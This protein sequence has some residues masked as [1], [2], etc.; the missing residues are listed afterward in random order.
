MV[1][2]KAKAKFERT[3][4]ATTGKFR[5]EG[6]EWEVDEARAKLLFDNGYVTIIDEQPVAAAEPKDYVVELEKPKKRG[7]KKKS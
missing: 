1:K 2:V 4:D 7:R 6:E 5:K 3:L